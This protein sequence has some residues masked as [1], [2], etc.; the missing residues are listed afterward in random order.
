MSLSVS[1]KAIAIIGMSC[2]TAGAN[3]PSELWDLLANSRDVQTEITRFNSRG[4]YHPEGAPRKGLTN[5]KHA[6]M[7]DDDAVDKFDNAFFHTTRHEAVAMDP[8]QRMLLEINYEAIENAG[9]PLDDFKGTNTAVFAGLSLITA[10]IQV[11]LWL[12]SRSGMEGCDYHTVL[13]RDLDATPRYLATGTPTCMAANRVSYFFDLSG[14]SISVDTACSSAMAALHQAVRT[15]QHRDSKM[16]L[17]CGAKLILSPDMFV[18]S[19]ELGFLSP[20]GK[21]Q[22]FDA[23]GDGYGRGEGVIAILLKPLRE[24]ITDGDPIRSVIKGTRLNQDGRTQGITLPSADAQKHNMKSLYQE[25]GI[26]PSDIHFLEAH[27]GPLH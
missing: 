2:R 7:L 5:V 13:A 24:A 18:P 17:V 12:T 27:V 6:Y 16:A 23:A 26:H 3:S 11:A 21:C 1:D 15:L 22:S 10:N 8:Q 19:S 9:I 25:L 20:S 14:P 4:Y